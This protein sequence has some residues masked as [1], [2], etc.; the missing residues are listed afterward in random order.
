M[1]VT[2]TASPA[3]TLGAAGLEMQ[4]RCLARRGMLH[5]ECESVDHVRLPAGAVLDTSGR[6]GVE[7]AWFVVAGDGVATGDGTHSLE[8]GDILLTR[9]TLGWKFQAGEGGLEMVWLGVLPESVSGK[10]PV[11]K[12][13]V[14]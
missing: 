9:V 1:I 11:R 14:P 5:S 10:L 7:S 3:H 6:A 8:Q 13:V 4:W 2:T 12:P